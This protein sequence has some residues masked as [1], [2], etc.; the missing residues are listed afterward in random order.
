MLASVESGPLGQLIP[1][2]PGHLWGRDT[3]DLTKLPR[4]HQLE[5]KPRRGK[6][7]AERVTYMVRVL[8]SP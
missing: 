1:M 8:L 7:P 6:G 5:G 4:S 2:L 3:S